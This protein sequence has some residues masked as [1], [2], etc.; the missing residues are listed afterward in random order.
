MQKIQ[1]AGLVNIL[2]HYSNEVKTIIK[3]Y[4]KIQF[5]TKDDLYKKGIVD[6]FDIL[7]IIEELEKIGKL[8]DELSYKYFVNPRFESEIRQLK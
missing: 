5:S 4:R 1:I 6:S 3:R 7:T 8:R 2:S